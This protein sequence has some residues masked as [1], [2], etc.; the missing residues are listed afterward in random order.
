MVEGSLYFLRVDTC[1]VH[2]HTPRYT[3]LHHK[4][5]S[6]QILC[7]GWQSVSQPVPGR[8]RKPMRQ[9]HVFRTLDDGNI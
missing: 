4:Y 6:I 3:K 5:Y 7:R 9:T 8:A 2:R 1:S